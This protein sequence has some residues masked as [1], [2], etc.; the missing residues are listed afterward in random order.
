VLGI[1]GL[2]EKKAFTA[3]CRLRQM[4]CICVIFPVRQL[5]GIACWSQDVTSSDDISFEQPHRVVCVIENK[6]LVPM[7][8]DCVIMSHE[9]N[10]AAPTTRVS[11]VCV[12]VC[13]CV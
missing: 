3:D 7:N 8:T 13:V 5:S 4:H 12:F 11:C 10:Y 1:R 2:P 9:P 6:L